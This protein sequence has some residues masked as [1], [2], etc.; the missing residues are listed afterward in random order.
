MDVRAFNAECDEEP[1]RCAYGT[2]ANQ[3][4]LIYCLTIVETP[5]QSTTVRRVVRCVS[6]KI[7]NLTM[8][9]FRQ[10]AMF[11]ECQFDSL[12]ECDCPNCRYN[13]IERDYGFGNF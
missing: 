9:E 7:F 6:S 5:K 3:N 12:R 11:R 4:A 2:N 10:A 13:N 8:D 1:L